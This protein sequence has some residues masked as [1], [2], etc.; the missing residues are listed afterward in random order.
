V[1]PAAADMNDLIRLL[2][3]RDANTRVVLLGT[4]LLGLTSGVIGSFAVLRRRALLGD[5]LAHASLPGICVAYLIVGD[6]NLPAFLVGAVVFGT[7]GVLVIS[8][9][10]AYT[11]I[12]EDAAIGLVLSTFFG[13]GIVLSRLIQNQPAGNRAGLDSYLFGKAAAMVRDD[14]YAIAAVG[15]VALGS[16]VLFFRAFRLICFDRDFA[17]AQGWPV[18]RL[19]VALMALLCVC[20]VIGLPAVGVVLMAALLIIPAAAARF[21]TDRLAA[22]LLIAGGIGMSSAMIGTAISALVAHL[23]AGPLI[24]LVAASFFVLSVLLAPRRGVVAEYVRRRRMQRRIALQNVLRAL[25]ELGEKS[26]N[27][28]EAHPLGLVLAKRDW[29][30]PRL[31]SDIDRTAA[32]GLVEVGPAGVRLTQPGLTE[33]SRIVRTH[34]LWELFLITQADVSPDH[35]DRDADQIEHVLPAELIERL[36]KRLAE[37]GRLPA[38]IPNSPHRLEG[39]MQ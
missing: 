24:V 18:F 26:G 20:T 25:Y 23:P 14:V 2:L 29:K 28:T 22:M 4:G 8:F 21:W 3:L 17:A 16:I 15:A 12:K 13:L 27:Q 1:P 19:D 39:T 32:I 11:R 35:V 10:R 30:A 36:E 33:A 5:A 38:A 6:K 37:E 31:L 34:R 9:L 7:L